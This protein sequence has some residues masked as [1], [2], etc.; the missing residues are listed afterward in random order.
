[1]LE[2]L[3]KEFSKSPKTI[4][5]VIIFGSVARGDYRP[6]S[7]VDVA[8]IY[9]GNLE[10]TKSFA[11]KVADRIYLNF[12]MPVTIIYI[13]ENDFEAEKTQFIRTIKKEGVTIW[14]RD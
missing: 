5:E 8:V 10:K 4:K 1:M 7:D 9:V 6:D 3:K 13:S 2:I 14:K 11:E 12:S